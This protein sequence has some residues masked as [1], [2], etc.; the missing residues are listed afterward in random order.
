MSKDKKNE[1]QHEVKLTVEEED[2]LNWLQHN[3]ITRAK[4]CS[5]VARMSHYAQLAVGKLIKNNN[6]LHDTVHSLEHQLA[7]D[8]ALLVGIAGLPQAMGQV[9]DEDLN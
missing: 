1:C 8:E 5:P 7:E 2:A 6:T 4:E 9:K 3:L